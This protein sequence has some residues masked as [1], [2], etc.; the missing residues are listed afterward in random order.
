M[1]WRFD[2]G[3]SDWG[4]VVHADRWTVPSN[5]V[6][7]MAKNRRRFQFGIRALLLLLTVF[8]AIC[9][10]AATA[11]TLFLILVSLFASF[12]VACVFVAVWATLSICAVDVL[13]RLVGREKDSGDTVNEAP[14][15]SSATP[16]GTD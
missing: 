12:A 8:S 13:C 1:K 16:V 3:C 9:S 7:T 2:A 6:S 11:P 4:G 14:V 5:A 10:L 15:E